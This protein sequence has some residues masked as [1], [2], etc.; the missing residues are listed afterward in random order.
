METRI[1]YSEIYLGEYVDIVTNEDKTGTREYIRV[2][3][4]NARL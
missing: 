4:G 3:S 2:S 1:Y